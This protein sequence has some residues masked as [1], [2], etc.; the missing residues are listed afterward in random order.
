MIEQTKKMRL[1]ELQIESFVT[2]SPVDA[3]KTIQVHGGNATRPWWWCAIETI[4]ISAEICPSIN[5]P[6]CPKPE[7]SAPCSMGGETHCCG[8][9]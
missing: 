9:P 8:M 2:T 4:A 5:G 6:A 1:D 7:P 3:Q